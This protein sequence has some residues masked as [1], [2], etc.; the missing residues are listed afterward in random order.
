MFKLLGKL[1][2]TMEGILTVIDV[3]VN[4]VERLSHAGNLH[5]QVLE[6]DVQSE[7]QDA[8]KAIEQS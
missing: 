7:L 4:T 5:A 3:N 6:A 2:D 1:W 8:L